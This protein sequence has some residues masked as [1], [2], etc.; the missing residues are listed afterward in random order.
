[1]ARGPFLDLKLLRRRSENRGT[2][3]I[4]KGWATWSHF[5]EAK[6]F[7]SSNWCEGISHQSDTSLQHYGALR[8]DTSACLV[9]KDTHTHTLSGGGT[10]ACVGIKQGTER[11]ACTDASPDDP[12]PPALQ[13]STSTG[14]KLL[15]QPQVSS[16]LTCRF[17][18]ISLIATARLNHR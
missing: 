9:Y 17:L 4:K 8:T 12:Q 1:M 2:L 13:L 15:I 14:S 6:N 7:S 11:Q 18:L 3:G 10:G 16:T 5:I